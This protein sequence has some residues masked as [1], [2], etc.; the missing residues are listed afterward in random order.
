MKK[1]FRFF[2]LYVLLILFWFAISGEFNWSNFFAG[3]FFSFLVILTTQILLK[4]MH[5]KYIKWAFV[6]NTSVFFIVSVRHIVKSAISQCR[7][8]IKNK[9]EYRI[10]HIELKVQDSFVIAMIANVV[11]LSPG[12][13][14]MAID[15][16]NLKII[17]AIESNEDERQII[18]E[19]LMLQEAFI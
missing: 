5:I 18:D 7:L 3:T 1:L 11:T 2:Q 12:T 19:I 13:V 10:I 6:K 16:Q 8:V 9:F 17:S 4:Q 14:T 15:N